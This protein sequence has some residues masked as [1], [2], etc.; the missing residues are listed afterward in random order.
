MPI[1]VLIMPSW[2]KN[3]WLAG[4]MGVLVL[5]GFA[6]ARANIVSPALA[7]PELEGLRTAF[8]GPH[9]NFDYFPALMEWSVSAGVVGLATLAFLPGIDRLPFFKPA[10]SVA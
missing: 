4:L 8:S 10:S 9:L 7:I 5:I 3:R 6:A 2:S 1:L